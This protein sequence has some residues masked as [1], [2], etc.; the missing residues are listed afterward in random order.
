MFLKEVGEAARAYKGWG[1]R[2][3]VN[4]YQD[5]LHLHKAPPARACAAEENIDF[6][7]D[8]LDPDEPTDSP[9]CNRV[10]NLFALGGQHL[11]EEEVKKPAATRAVSDRRFEKWCKGLEGTGLVRSLVDRQPKILKKLYRE[12]GGAVDG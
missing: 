7:L 5:N 4:V 11:K 6:C 10:E 9:D 2:H 3:R 1:H 12:K 8:P